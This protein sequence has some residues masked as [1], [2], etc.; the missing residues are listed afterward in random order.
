MNGSLH[1]ATAPPRVAL[2]HDFLVSMRGADRV[3][4]EITEMFPDADVFTPIYD[5]RGTE[6]RFAH[7]RIQTSF[8][9]RLRPNSR[10]FRAMLPLYPAAIESFDLSDYDLVVSSSSAWAHAVICGDHATHVCYCYNPFRYAWNERHR[11]L[12]ERGNVISRAVLRALFR[13]WRVWDWIAAQRVTRYVAISPTTQKRI[14]R[15]LGRDSEVL[16]PPV[17]CGRFTPA[18]P[19]QEYL[20]VS[21]LVSHKRIDEAVVA[22]SRLGLPLAVVGDGPDLR[23]L[24]SLAGPTVRFPGRLS[25]GVLN[26]MFAQ[27]RALVVT[28]VEEFG[29]AAVEAQAAGRPVLAKAGGGATETV[30]EGQTGTLWTGGVEGLERAVREFDPDTIDPRACVENAYRFDSAVFR[31]SFRAF[32]DEAMAQERPPKM[33]GGLRRRPWL[34]VATGRHDVP[35]SR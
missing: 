5:E 31:E 24:R 32:L 23:R 18:T 29:M 12:D 1:S 14:K 22:F 28:A 33:E 10:T 4:L 19:G 35:V 26:G 34:A 9:Q 7:R 13:R 16:F 6:G 21:E 17:D 25:D 2:V 11:S 3:F 20:L 15:Y 27:C 30:I 8:L